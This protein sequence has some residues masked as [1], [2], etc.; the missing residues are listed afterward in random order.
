M[1]HEFKELS[2]QEAFVLDWILQNFMLLEVI[3]KLSVLE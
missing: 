1:T 3:A 2:H